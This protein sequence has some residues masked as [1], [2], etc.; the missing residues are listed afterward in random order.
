MACGGREDHKRDLR[1]SELEKP[2]KPWQAVAGEE[3][4]KKAGKRVPS[5]TQVTK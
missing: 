1:P 5:N 4:G 3:A 2:P